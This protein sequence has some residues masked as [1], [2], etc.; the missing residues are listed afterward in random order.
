MV[1]TEFDA[2]ATAVGCASV[3]AEAM[4]VVTAGQSAPAVGLIRMH[5]ARCHSPPPFLG[6][7]V[8]LAL[9]ALA[10]RGSVPA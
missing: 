9:T 6:N 5:P 7:R 2:G 1:R 8:N 10:A 4:A 3:R